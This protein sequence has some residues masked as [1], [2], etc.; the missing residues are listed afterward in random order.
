MEEFQPII[1]ILGTSERPSV[2]GLERLMSKND[3]EE[4]SEWKMHVN[5]GNFLLD[6]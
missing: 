1:Y 3:S 5:S 6:T 4:D 2:S